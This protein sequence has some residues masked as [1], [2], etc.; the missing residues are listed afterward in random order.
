MDLNSISIKTKLISIT[1]IVVFL[2]ALAITFLTLYQHQKLY[3]ENLATNLYALSSNLSDELFPYMAAPQPE[4]IGLTTTLL[5]LERYQQIKFGVVLNKSN[6]VVAQYLN[7]EFN[8]DTEGFSTQDWERILK[9]QGS[10]FIE[11]LMEIHLIGDEQFSTGNLIIVADLSNQLSRN[12][13]VF[14]TQLIPLILLIILIIFVLSHWVQSGIIT[15][16]INLSHLVSSVGKT[17]NYQLRYKGHGQDEVSV[18][19]S[20]INEMLSI[21]NE[22]DIENKR[23]TIKLLKQQKSLKHLADYDQLT[24]LPNRKLFSELL[25]QE[26]IKAKRTNQELA[27]MFLDLDDFKTV[28]DTIGHHAGDVLLQLV[29]D[30]VKA[31]L[32]EGDT[33]ARLGGDEF[34]VIL[35]ELPSH[36]TAVSIAQRILESFINYFYV[37]EWEIQSGLSIGIAFN[38][39]NRFDAAALISNADVAMYKAKEGGRGQF[40]VFEDKMQSVQH[41]HMLI[42]NELAKAISNDEF[43]LYY[44]P[45]VSPLLGVIGFEALIR[46]HSQFDGLVSPAEFIPVAEHCGRVHDITRWVLKQG[47]KDLSFIN[48][49]FGPGVITSFNVSAIDIT[50][51]GFIQYLEALIKLNKSK[52]DSIEFEV[53]ESSYIENFE[54]A[55]LFFKALNEMGCSIALDDFGTGYSSLSYL[56]QVKA[57]TLKIDQQFVKKIFSSDSDRLIVESIIGLAKKLNL[58]VCAE[59]VETKEQYEFLSNFDCELIQGYYFSKPVPLEDLKSKVDSIHNSHVFSGK[60]S[61]VIHL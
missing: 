19:G 24:G 49:W 38:E 53:T 58:K 54:S 46:W 45:K 61:N 6:K 39:K 55:S 23:H 51:K 17:K 11:S 52:T 47:L 56:T 43:K 7:P 3:K 44:Q 8:L 18:L 10:D 42:A 36:L 37:Q 16:L 59:G 5:K 35:T 26:L 33:L 57:N 13:Q 29:S 34:I 2:C 9:N 30:R 4:F 27:V 20:N 48:D 1:F 31:Q 28:N 22:Q 12:M 60:S 15:P 14:I 41:R 25:K 21:I 32:R 50:K 40:A